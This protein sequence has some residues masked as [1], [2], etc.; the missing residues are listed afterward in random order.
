MN[1]EILDNLSDI[2]ILGLTIIGEA[3]GERIQGQVA[4]GSVIRNRLMTGKKSYHEVCLEKH[5]FSCWND[6]DPNRAV[7]LE[8]AEM[9]AV[10]QFLTDQYY[11]QCMFVAK[12]IVGWNIIDNTQGAT[13]YMTNELF[14][15][16]SKP[17]WAM[18]A[19]NKEQIGNHIFFNV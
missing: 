4:V 17:E 10:G 18:N 2:E 6:K 16:T 9:L 11:K 19:K 1:T 13:H 3:R 7:L 12:G 15:S 8:L 14:V 5:Q